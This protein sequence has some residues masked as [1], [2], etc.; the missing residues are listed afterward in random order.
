[1]LE[2]IRFGLEV[3]ALSGPAECPFGTRGMDH[4]GAVHEYRF[5]PMT[6]KEWAENRE[7]L[8]KFFS[9]LTVDPDGSPPTGLHVHVEVPPAVRGK[10]FFARLARL[11]AAVEEDL[12]KEKPVSAARKKYAREW[13]GN[14]GDIAG[15]VQT[16]D[17]CCLDRYRT[18]NLASY[19]EH[20]TVEFRL[21]NGTN[22]FGE[23]EE[24]VSFCLAVVWTAAAG[25]GKK[26]AGIPVEK[27]KKLAY[28]AGRKIFEAL[29]K[30]D[31]NV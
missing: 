26:T 14:C 20:G 5:R 4:G 27:E 21:W 11:W 13:F 29:T 3:E 31:K 28:T 30:G 23:A 24:I 6:L 15:A 2:R 12:K 25:C 8:R 10:Q 22:D 9:A 1:M 18:L 16:G 7:S 17:Y 19:P